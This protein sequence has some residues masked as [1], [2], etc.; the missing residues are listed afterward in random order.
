MD[1]ELERSFV[2]AEEE[3]EARA[4]DATAEAQVFHR[5]CAVCHRTHERTPPN[6]LHGDAARVSA[7]LKHC[8]PRIFARLSMGQ[9]APAARDKT[10]MPPPFASKEGSPG[11]VALDAKLLESLTAAAARMLRS[12]TGQ[13]P[14]L[15]TMLS[16]GYENLRPCL[17]AERP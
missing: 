5:H 16:K 1:P 2:P 12:E 15:A 13:A 11:E 14:V 10:P 17:P 9:L 6:F 7:A 8:A 4:A 3:L